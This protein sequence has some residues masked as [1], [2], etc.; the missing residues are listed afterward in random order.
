MRILSAL[1]LLPLA[2]CSVATTGG[3]RTNLLLSDKPAPRAS[4]QILYQPQTLPAISQLADSTALLETLE[5]FA[6]TYPLR[7][8]RHRALYSVAW[9]SEGRIERL[10]PIDYWLPRDQ[11]E[12]FT[13]LVRRHLQPQMPGAGSLRLLLQPGS[14]EPVQIGYSERCPPEARTRFRLTAPAIVQQQRPQPVRVRM[15]VDTQGR[16]I[17]T[18]LLS[19]SGSVELDR[20]VA[21]NLQRRQFAPGLIDGFPVA[22]DHEETIRIAA[23]P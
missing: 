3:D 10:N 21:D 14:P 17:G 12:N 19:S 8:G 15:H 7:E 16:V 18:Q 22:M 11:A 4:C 5:E 1:I 13:S 20:W 23:R 9:T 2:A 6:R